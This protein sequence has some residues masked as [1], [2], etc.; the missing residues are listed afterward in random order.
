[1]DKFHFYCNLIVIEVG[2]ITSTKFPHLVL[3]KEVLVQPGW[4]CKS[5]IC[6]NFTFS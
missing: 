6:S 3:Y 5:Q 1:M 2:I 4:V